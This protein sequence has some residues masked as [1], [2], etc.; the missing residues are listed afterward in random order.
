MEAS[1]GY[2]RAMLEALATANPNELRD[3]L[4]ELMS[5][6]GHLKQLSFGDKMDLASRLAMALASLRLDN[7]VNSLRL[8]DVTRSL[9]VSLL[10]KAN[11]ALARAVPEVLEELLGAL[12]LTTASQ[13]SVPAHMQLIHF[14]T[15][16]I[17]LECL[18]LPKTN[19]LWLRLDRHL[20][21]VFTSV[22][23]S[24]EKTSL[25]PPSD[26]PS[27]SWPSFD[28]CHDVAVVRSIQNFLGTHV[29]ETRTPL[30]SELFAIAH[31]V[32]F[33][34]GLCI[35]VAWIFNATTTFNTLGVGLVCYG[36]IQVC[37]HRERSRQRHAL[38]RLALHR[39]ELPYAGDTWCTP[40]P[41]DDKAKPTVNKMPRQ[42]ASAWSEPSGG[43]HGN[44]EGHLAVIHEEDHE[45][46][47]M[48]KN[49]PVDSSILSHINPAEMLETLQRLNSLLAADDDVSAETRE[50]VQRGLQ[51]LE[52]MG[53]IPTDE[54]K[55]AGTD[56]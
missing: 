10:D 28:H 54:L 55:H 9:L 18:D 15:L 53:T 41:S 27:A 43:D 49:P 31:W 25:P 21:P 38:L 56:K 3:A 26:V 44:S 47:E 12:D 48:P 17:A 7:S 20:G 39:C 30:Q 50:K 16:A 14:T 51:V 33:V 11:G 2:S 52:Q 37:R 24:G 45:A 32:A 40:P 1:K 6:R 19:P 8:L 23:A 4:N 36:G 42:V 34:A 29:T 5:V 46:N 13:Q 35:I 22:A